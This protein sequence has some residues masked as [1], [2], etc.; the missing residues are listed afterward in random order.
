MALNN[1]LSEQQ[2]IFHLLGSLL[3]VL[4]VLISLTNNKDLYAYAGWGAILGVSFLFYSFSLRPVEN[5]ID[6]KLK[7]IYQKDFYFFIFL[8]F[9]FFVTYLSIA[10]HLLPIENFSFRTNLAIILFL[11]VL[12]IL[13]RNWAI[14]SFFQSLKLESQ[15]IF[16]KQKSNLYKVSYIILAIIFIGLFLLSLY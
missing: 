4:T 9:L 2:K 16:K 1:K 12:Y 14:Y 8:F 13:Y 10:H 15:L 7:K 5:Q 6:L 11:L 3:L